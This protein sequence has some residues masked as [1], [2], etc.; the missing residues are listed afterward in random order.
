M[1]RKCTKRPT[2]LTCFPPRNG[3]STPYGSPWH[4]YLVQSEAR[5]AC[6]DPIDDIT[7]NSTQMLAG[8]NDGRG[9]LSCHGRESTSAKHIHEFRPASSGFRLLFCPSTLAPEGAA[10][11]NENA[12][13]S[14]HWVQ[15]DASLC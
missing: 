2:N 5:R 15:N 1:Q 10:H 11:E 14:G 6:N 9:R 8:S 12:P 13:T 7:K 4:E 3:C